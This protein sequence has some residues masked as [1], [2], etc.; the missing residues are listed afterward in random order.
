M[1]NKLT[2][3]KSSDPSSMIRGLVPCELGRNT[4]SPAL[5]EADAVIAMSV[6]GPI[7][8]EE[9]APYYADAENMKR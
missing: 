5:V 2:H 9:L 4:S 3:R 6:N 8:M 7:R 1:P